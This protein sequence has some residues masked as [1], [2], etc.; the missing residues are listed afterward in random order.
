MK[1]F[2]YLRVYLLFYFFRG[3]END[4][5]FPD[6]GYIH[7]QRR[8]RYSKTPSFS[9]YSW[10]PELPFWLVFN[11]KHKQKY[12]NSLDLVGLF[13][14]MCFDSDNCLVYFYF[15][16]LVPRILKFFSINLSGLSYEHEDYCL[17]VYGV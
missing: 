14:C 7:Y 4:I 10:I 17:F 13:V 9:L 6:V 15:S 16:C 1:S 2:L 11:L 3:R 5:F 12:L 8:R